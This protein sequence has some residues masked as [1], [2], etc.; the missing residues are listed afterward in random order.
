M[1]RKASRT[2][3]TL[4]GFTIVELL[5]VIVVIAILAAIT[6]VAYNGIQGQAN[7]SAVQSDLRQFSQKMNIYL[8]KHGP[9][10]EGDAGVA[11]FSTLETFNWRASQ[12]AYATSPS[13][14]TNLI[15]CHNYNP[16]GV[17]GDY[18]GSVAP[19]GRND[20]ALV[21]KSKSGK[22]YYVTDKQTAPR[23]YTGEIDFQTAAA[24]HHPCGVML[25]LGSAGFKS[26]YGGYRSADTGTGPWRAWTGGN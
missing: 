10:F 16:S 25:E 17:S 21:A 24:T 14:D 15:F 13:T 19:A 3:L 8:A 4:K 9:S 7:D 26:V 22:V 23:L 6:I 20:W 12:A 5:I 1:A 18:W 2:T 11:V